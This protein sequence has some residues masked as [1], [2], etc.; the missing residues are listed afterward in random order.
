[1]EYRWL[2]DEEI[3][4]VLNPALKVQGFAQMNINPAQP[5][6]RVRGCFVD[7]RLVK[8]FAFQM[9][10]I[11]GPMVTVDN[12]FRD[13]GDVSRTLAADMAQFFEN[14]QARGCLCIA[15]SPVTQR[16]CE[17]FGMNKL[18]SPVY[19]YVRD[20]IRDTAPTS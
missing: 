11:L 17:R 18:E 2:N 4:D 19:E 9:Y 20:Q 5:L 13:N 3:A 1:M 16:L 12:T 15:D 7:G 6:C 14:A 8:A 10:P